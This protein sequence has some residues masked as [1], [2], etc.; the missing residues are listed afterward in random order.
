[1]GLGYAL[2]EEMHFKNGEVLDTNFDTL[3]A[4]ALLVAAE[5]R[6]R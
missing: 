1:M 6:R 5:D 3:R 4:A 2:A